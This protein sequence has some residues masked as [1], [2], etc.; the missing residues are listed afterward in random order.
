MVTLADR[1]ALERISILLGSGLAARLLEGQ[2]IEHADHTRSS[3]DDGAVDAS[4][5][6]SL[7]ACERVAAFTGRP[8]H[9]IL[10]PLSR[11]FC[12]DSDY[13]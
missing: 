6:L 13:A 11:R 7:D 8:I 3:C 9:C 12:C 1:G 10:K 5:S 4:Q 2:K